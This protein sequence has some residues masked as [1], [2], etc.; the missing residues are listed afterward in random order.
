MLIAAVLVAT[1]SPAQATP[2]G[3]SL[4]AGHY[5][6]AGGYITAYKYWFCENG[7]V[8]LAVDIDRYLSPNV[9]ENV[10]SGYGEVTYY[11]GGWDFRRYRTSNTAPFEILCT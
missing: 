6:S 1:P 7:D 4:G 2:P 5:E 3:C 9:W 10:A 11:C 8:P